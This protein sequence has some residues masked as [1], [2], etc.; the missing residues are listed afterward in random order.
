MLEVIA[1][2]PFRVWSGIAGKR[3]G[4]DSNFG[5]PEG[6]DEDS[7]QLKKILKVSQSREGMGS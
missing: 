6:A 3:E 7:I 5:K 2:G 4:L 1:D